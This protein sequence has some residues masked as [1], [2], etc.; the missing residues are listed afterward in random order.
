MQLV[1]WKLVDKIVRALMSRGW[2]DTVNPQ[3]I[4]VLFLVLARDLKAGVERYYVI[5]QEEFDATVSFG[6]ESNEF[7][8]VLRA[9]AET[10][11]LRAISDAIA[12]LRRIYRKLYACWQEGADVDRELSE[13]HREQM[14]DYER[15]LALL[16]DE[17]QGG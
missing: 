13:E 17:H 9:R 12:V 15:Q 4:A 10:E 11:D 3:E 5:E 8:R 14:E 6:R 7:I 1:K 2:G 16:E